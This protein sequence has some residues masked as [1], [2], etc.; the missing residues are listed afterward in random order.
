[1]S[2]NSVIIVLIVSVMVLIPVMFL[3]YQDAKPNSLVGKG[4]FK[5]I[6]ST[7][8]AVGPLDSV[9]STLVVDSL[10]ISDAISYY[11]YRLKAVVVNQET[12]WTESKVDVILEDSSGERQTFH[13]YGDS[14]R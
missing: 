7:D 5:N 4:D 2:K 11:P 8:T 10:I 13:F 14:R 1:M 3:M 12:I 6:I 9:A